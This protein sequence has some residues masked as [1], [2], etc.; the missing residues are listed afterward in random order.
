V[1]YATIGVLAMREALGLGGTTTGPGG[2][3]Q[4]MGPQP[5]CRVLLIVLAAGLVGYALW[6]LVQGIMDPDQKGSDPDDILRRVGYVGSSVIHGGL[7]FI[8]AQ[9]VPSSRHSPSSVRKI[10]W[11]T[12][13]RRAPWL[14]N[15]HSTRSFSGWSD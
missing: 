3:M 10:A 6:N 2:A 4:N 1:V 5:Q 13:W 7:A 14:S 12:P 9:S 15:P 8:A 11:K